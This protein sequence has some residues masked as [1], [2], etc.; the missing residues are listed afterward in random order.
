[1]PSMTRSELLLHTICDL[2]KD[3]DESARIRALDPTSE[4]TFAEAYCAVRNL[5]TLSSELRSALM[6]E[7]FERADAETERQLAARAPRPDASGLAVVIPLQ[8][9]RGQRLLQGAGEQQRS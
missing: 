6:A 8:R 2:I 3:P 4:T 5:P 7:I 1:M 9:R